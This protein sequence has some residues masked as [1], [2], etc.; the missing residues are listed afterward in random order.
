VAT[1]VG[2]LAV[3]IGLATAVVSVMNG[4]L[5]RR[6]DLADAPRPR[7]AH[8]PKPARGLRRNRGAVRGR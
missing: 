2:A 8:E 7:F 4:I 3:A 1:V 5:F 6:V